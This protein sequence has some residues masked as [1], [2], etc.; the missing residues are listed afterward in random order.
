M[1]QT[2]LQLADASL[3]KGLIGSSAF[4]PNNF[5]IICGCVN[6]GSGSN[7]VISEG[8]I[9]GN[10]KMYI[11]DATSFT[12]A[13]GQTAVGKIDIKSFRQ[14]GVDN[15]SLE[16][17]IS[18]PDHPIPIIKFYSGDTDSAD[19]NLEDLIAEHPVNQSGGVN[20]TPEII[21]NWLTAPTNVEDALNMLAAKTVT[22]EAEMEGVLPANEL[23]STILT[24]QV[25]P[26]KIVSVTGLADWSGD[27]AHWIGDK[28]TDSAG[29]YY[30]SM[31]TS[32]P[33]GGVTSVV[34]SVKS[35]STAIFNKAVRV[36]LKY[37]K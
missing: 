21:A 33:G 14:Y 34:I 13:V 30:W 32:T 5:Y 9:F 16:Y 18:L 3:A 37:K 25:D 36:L 31:M 20:Y 11:V 24:F 22:F 12:A 17:G 23:S 6:S 19:V 15:A 8:A 26:T 35:T 1:N 10:N 27:G 7:Y 2:A 4:S 29:I 28:D